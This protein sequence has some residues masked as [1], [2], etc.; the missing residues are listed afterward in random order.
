MYP[1]P[2]RKFAADS[3]L[4]KPQRLQNKVFRTTGQ[5]PGI[6]LNRE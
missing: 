3:H 6:T 1:C 5:F 4:L 2:D